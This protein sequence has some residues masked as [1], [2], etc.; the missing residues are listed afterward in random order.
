M[1]NKIPDKTI[2][3]FIHKNTYP[4]EKDFGVPITKI[5]ESI[6]QLR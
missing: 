6:G 4:G 3:V 5:N 1:I 2:P